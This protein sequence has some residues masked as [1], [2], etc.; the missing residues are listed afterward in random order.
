MDRGGEGGRET[1][2]RLEREGGGVM[3]RESERGGERKKRQR[4]DSDASG[5]PFI[6]SSARA[7]QMKEEREIQING[8]TQG[9]IRVKTI[10]KRGGG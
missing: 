5:S 3:G 10:R 7:E 9:Y 6:F 2:R 1:E 8:Y 4:L